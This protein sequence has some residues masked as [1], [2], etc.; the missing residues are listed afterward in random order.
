MDKDLYQ[1]IL[2]LKDRVICTY[3]EDKKVQSVVVDLEKDEKI[4]VEFVKGYVIVRTQYEV[5]FVCKGNL[6]ISLWR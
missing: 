4:G 3:Y 1:Q 6:F 5:K 2:E